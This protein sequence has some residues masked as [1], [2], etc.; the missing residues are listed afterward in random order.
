MVA[1]LCG[2]VEQIGSFAFETG[3]EL[4][5]AVDRQLGGGESP[6]QTC[7]LRACVGEQRLEVV[8]AAQRRG[9]RAVAV[10]HVCGCGWFGFPSL[11]GAVGADAVGVAEPL[12][13]ST[14]FSR[15]RHRD[16]C[17]ETSRNVHRPGNDL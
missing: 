11:A 10:G 13:W 6:S 2:L 3:G 8:L 9:E 5:E 4:F 16:H 14:T 12:A 17:N 1:Q 7:D 15:D